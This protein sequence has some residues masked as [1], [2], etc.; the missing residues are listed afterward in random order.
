MNK[1]E[2]KL[3][4]LIIEGNEKEAIEL[5]KSDETINVNFVYKKR[6][7]IFSAV[8]EKMYTLFETIIN[9]PKFDC[10]SHIE[11]GFGETIFQSLIWL[12]NADE[13]K[14][15]EAYCERKKISDLIKMILK[16]NTYDFNYQDLNLDTALHVA[17][18]Y[19]EDGWITEALITKEYTNINAIN[20]MNETPLAVAIKRNNIEAIKLL[21]KRKDLI[22][23]DVDVKEAEKNNIDLA[24][25]GIN[26]KEL[27]DTK[28]VNV[29]RRAKVLVESK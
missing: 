23:R 17:C 19:L 22:V 18:G 7:L 20:D 24:D 10:H 29:S 25:Y 28:V 8:N 21:S 3:H 9:H 13:Y 5:L 27:K 6:T 12:Y 1:K 4:K 2:I 14:E 26:V 16:T 11:D 15:I